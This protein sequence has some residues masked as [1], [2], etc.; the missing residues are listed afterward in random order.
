MYWERTA[1]VSNWHPADCVHALV[2][3]GP[4][5]AGQSRTVC[6]KFYLIEGTKD[7]LLAAWQ[8]DFSIRMQ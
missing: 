1:Y 4:L 8:R 5:D 6:G 3:F 2:D 7:D